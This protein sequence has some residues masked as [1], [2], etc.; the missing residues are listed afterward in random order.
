MAV[1]SI[2][3]CKVIKLTKLI[4]ATKI[5]NQQYWRKKRS[6]NTQIFFGKCFV[7]WRNEQDKK[8]VK[9]ASCKPK[10]KLHTE[11]YLASDNYS[12]PFLSTYFS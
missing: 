4:N 8:T 11:P 7:L 9:T 10:R 5:Y 6:A 2:K 1:I 3:K 12:R